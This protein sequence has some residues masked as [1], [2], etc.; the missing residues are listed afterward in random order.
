MEKDLYPAF[1]RFISRNWANRP[2]AVFELKR[3]RLPRFNKNLV[4]V[5][6]IRAL[7]MSSYPTGVYHKISDQSMGA[8]PFD[9]FI[10]KDA[11]GYLV[12]CFDRTCHF[13][14]VHTWCDFVEDRTS[15]T[16]EECMSISEIQASL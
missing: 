10:I 5:H 15:V 6:Q 4:E 1:S 14:D 3:T 2:T 11:K 16:E 9:S 7:K 13:I 8:K 12:V